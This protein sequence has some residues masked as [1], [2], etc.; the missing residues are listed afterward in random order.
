M[1]SIANK[2]FQKK[3]FEVICVDDKS[4]DSTVKIIK[5]FK[6]VRLI[7]LP[8]NAGNGRAKNI[9]VEAAKGE[10]LFFVDDHIYLRKDTLKKI[11]QIFN[12]L[13]NVDGVCGNYKSLKEK[14]RNVCRDIRRRT[15]Y[16][17]DSKIRFITCDNF[18]PFSITIGALRRELF[19]EHRFPE[20]FGKD[21]CED[22]AFEIQLLN[23]NKTFL[24][25]PLIRGY[26]DHNLSNF[27]ILS[28]VLT[29]IRGTGNLIYFLLNNDQ[30]IPFQYGFLSYPLLELLRN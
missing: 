29:E 18:S 21:S 19:S 10:I 7:Q 3:Q 25:S 12:T 23:N 9:G 2:S 26:H 27:G 28:K 4:T 16:L 17:K 13:S 1:S 8:R 11:Y 24:Y 15:I 22:I 14:D 6:S 5:K 20:H 30:K